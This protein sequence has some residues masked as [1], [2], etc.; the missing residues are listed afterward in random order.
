MYL[1]EIQSCADHEIAERFKG[2]FV[3][4]F[5]DHVV[6][7]DWPYSELIRGKVL[8]NDDWKIF[9]TFSDRYS[10]PSDDEPC[11]SMRV[12]WP[13][14]FATYQSESNDAKKRRI[15]TSVHAACLWVARRKN[16]SVQPFIDAYEK[17]LESGVCWTFMSKKQWISPTRR[18]KARIAVEMDLARIIHNHPTKVASAAS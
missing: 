18:T 5:M 14:D 9:I 8:A 12:H 1:R 2:G 3:G 6:C 17:L 16:W 11:V 15:L 10:T 7:V 4:R 13:F